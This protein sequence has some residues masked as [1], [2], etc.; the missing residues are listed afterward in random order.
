MRQTRNAQQCRCVEGEAIKPRH[1]GGFKE[2]A[3]DGRHGD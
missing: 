1:Y 3:I 2:R